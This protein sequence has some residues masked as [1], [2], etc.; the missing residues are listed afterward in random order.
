MTYTSNWFVPL[1]GRV[2]FYFAWSLAAE[3]Q[4][5][6]VWPG[7]QKVLS[8][9][10][11][12]SVVILVVIV[13]AVSQWMTADYS[14]PAQSLPLKVLNSVPLA[15]CLGVVLAYILHFKKGFLAMRALFGPKSCSLGWLLVFFT[16]LNWS[17]APTI[18]IHAAA[19]MLVGAC[20]YREDHILAR[21]LK[22]RTLAYI[23]TISY[24]V[25]ML[26][27]LV[28]NA[29]SKVLIGMNMDVFPVAVFLITALF[30]VLLAG[31]SFRYFESIF[32]GMR[33]R[34]IAPVRD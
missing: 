24:G 13:V 30:S 5:Y 17:S 18:V 15:I 1:E 34:F 12:L 19:V 31:L 32:V 27:M 4:F 16:V 2:I 28:K 14:H 11:A 26:H 33:N 20:V 25:Y 7:L 3:E 22:F 29:V 23:G 9:K 8:P 6:L 10:Y 21:L